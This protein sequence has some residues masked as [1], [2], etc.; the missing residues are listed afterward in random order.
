MLKASYLPSSESESESE[1]FPSLFKTESEWKTHPETTSKEPKVHREKISTGTHTFPKTLI[2][3]ANPTL[4]H[5]S[6]QKVYQSYPL[7][8]IRS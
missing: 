5:K 7:W 1:C 8:R 3:Y 6:D 2:L 4:V